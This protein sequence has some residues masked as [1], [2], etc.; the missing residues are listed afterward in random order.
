MSEQRLNPAPSR[1]WLDKISQILTGEPKDRQE[2]VEMLRDATERRLLDP[3]SLGMIEGVLEVPEIR[4]RDI[5]LPRSQMIVIERNVPLEEIVTTVIRYGHSRFPVIGENKDEVL[6]ILLAKD[7]LAY[8]Y[9][10]K[11]IP[12]KI[13][14]IL[15]TAV[16]IPESK[17]L[18]VLLQ[19]F[20]ATRNHMAVVV[21]EYGGVTGLVTIENVIEQ[22]VGEIEDE[23]DVED[24]QLIKK[25]SEHTYS[26]HA[27]TPIEEFNKYF[28]AHLQEKDLETVGGLVMRGF[29]R[30]PKRGET[31]NISSYHFKILRADK[32][33]V[34][35][36]QM[37]T[38]PL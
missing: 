4:V 18:D 17:R 9:N 24:D 32:R 8:G 29:G 6:G 35:L 27:L 23:Y 3:H 13:D 15:R 26:I 11:E 30:L 2:L 38:S 14:D 19:E 1:S 7:L 37:S 10:R 31:V 36:L 12:F 25:L 28:K 20:R 16:F 34:H 22:I 21:D 5:M 33:R